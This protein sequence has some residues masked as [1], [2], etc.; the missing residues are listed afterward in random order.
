MKAMHLMLSAA[1][2]AILIAAP[3]TASAQVPVQPAGSVAQRE[4]VGALD[5]LDG[6]WRGQAV[7]HGPGG[8]E[9]LTQT[10][11]VG[12][13]LGGSI[14]VIEGRGYA[15]DGTTM[16]NAMAVLS[17]NERE[18]RYGFRSYANGYSGDYRFE[19]TEDGF[20]WET[21]A[22]PNARIEYVAVVRDGTWHEVGT[23]IAEGQPPR[24]M[25]DMRLTRVGDTGWPAEGAV[26]PR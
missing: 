4:A 5:F 23:Y 3:V 8:P 2:A 9:T 25:I 21:P 10:E 6:E 11:R 17:W 7:V 22:G 13:F 20:R 18:G 19:R 16:F 14:K 1:A 12:S 26:S 15:A 24:P